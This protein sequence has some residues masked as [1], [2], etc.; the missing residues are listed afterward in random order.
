MLIP[1]AIQQDAIQ[2]IKDRITSDVYESSTAAY[3][4][5]WFCVLKGDRKSLRLV[6]DLQPLNLVT[7]R[8]T[9]TPPFVEQL[10]ESFAGYA[11]YG[12][13]DL[14]ARYDQPPLHV[15]SR[16]MT[17]FSS[18]LGPQR[19]TI[20]PMGYTNVVQIYQADMSFILQEEIPHY[21]MPFIND[22]PVKSGTTRYQNEDESYKTMPETSGICRFIWEHLIVVNQILQHLQNVGATVSTTNFVLA[23]PDAVIVSHKCT[24]KGWIPHE[25]KGQNIQDWPDCASVRL[26]HIRRFLGTCGVLHIFI[27]NFAV[28]ARPLVNL[29]RKGVPFEWGDS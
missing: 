3:R 12:M 15:E 1:A 20:L 13:M 17:T 29:T 10:A 22:L 9:S 7:I 11:V 23:A 19:L 27:W 25:A 4:S 24:F 21:T 5:C 18:P 6:H 28:I 26:T 16:D 14:F 2:I 8:D